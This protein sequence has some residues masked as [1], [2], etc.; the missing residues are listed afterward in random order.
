ML[1]ERYLTS[2]ILRPF[3][4]GLAMLTAV[5]VA[6]SAA[7][8]L[9]DAAGGK[10]A[11]PV[12]AELIFLNTLASMEVL[13]PT[14][15][16]LAIIFGVGRLHRDSEMTALESA[17]VGETRVLWVAG[18]IALVCTLLVAWVSIELRPWVYARSYALEQSNISH[19]DISNIRPGTFVDMGSGGYVLYAQEVDVATDEMHDVFVQVDRGELSQVIAAA[20]ARIHSMD[21]EDS[22]SVEFFDGYSYLLDRDGLRDLEMHYGSFLIRFPQ[23]ERIARARRKATP[24][25]ALAHSDHPKE[26]AEYQWR[27]ST[28][29]A[30][31]L[32]GLIAVP[33]SRANPRQTRNSTLAMAIA[34]YMLVFA[35][36]SAVRNALESGDIPQFPGMLLAYLPP[37]VLL[38]MLLALPRLRLRRARR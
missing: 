3:A 5:S 1:I 24:T 25:E 18:A 38:G 29:I 4:A 30:T 28:P 9:S 12:V 17:G 35:T 10:I 27:L 31:L 23:E 13:I 21:A 33:L 22:R 34:A 6:F 16:F 19:F 26:I 36:L 2:E 11:A 7:V 20:R 32:L 15:L 8:R 14:T 37:L